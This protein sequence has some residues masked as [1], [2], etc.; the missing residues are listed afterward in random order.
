MYPVMNNLRKLGEGGRGI[1]LV[2]APR[3]EC[4]GSKAKLSPRYPVGAVFW[5]NRRVNWPAPRPRRFGLRLSQ[6]S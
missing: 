3:P 6:E 2:N 4:S 5:E 1:F